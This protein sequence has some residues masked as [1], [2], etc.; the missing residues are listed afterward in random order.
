MVNGGGRWEQASRANSGNPVVQNRAADLFDGEKTGRWDGC[1]ER[2][3]EIYYRP[4]TI[5]VGN[6]L[7]I[8]TTDYYNHIIN[9]YLIKSIGY[10]LS[11]YFS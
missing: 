10:L 4:L 7:Y 3:K 8:L 11:L 5:M 2:S 9:N 1:I 6:I